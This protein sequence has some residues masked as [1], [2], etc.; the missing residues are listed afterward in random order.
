MST[1]SFNPFLLAD[2]HRQRDTTTSTAVGRSSPPM[3]STTATTACHATAPTRTTTT[4]I[5]SFPT[6]LTNLV[7]EE[8]CEEYCTL[9]QDIMMGDRAVKKTKPDTL[10]AVQAY[11]LDPCTIQNHSRN[12]DFVDD[13]EDSSTSST[14][15]FR[16]VAR[17][18]YRAFLDRHGF[19]DKAQAAYLERCL[20]YTADWCAKK[21][22]FAPAAMAWLKLRE[23]GYIPRE[24]TVSTFLFVF[25]LE[26]DNNNDKRSNA[27]QIAASHFLQD[28]AIFHDA[29]F[30]PNEK[31][32]YLRIKSL[33]AAGRAQEADDLLL[34]AIPMDCQR[35]RTFTPLLTHYCCIDDHDKN[36]SEDDKDNDVDAASHSLRLFRHMRNAPG[37]YLDADTYVMLLTSLAQREFFSCQDENDKN[38]NVGS[39]DM[40]QEAGFPVTGPALFD[41]LM[42][43]MST[44]LLE[45]NET[46]AIALY[47][48]LQSAF[49]T[50]E[51]PFDDV[52]NKNARTGMTSLPLAASH[53]SSMATIT[54]GRVTVDPTTC[55][56]PAT[57]AKL[58]LFSLTA[59]QRTMVQHTLLNMAAAQHEEFAAKMQQRNKKRSAPESS[60]GAYA[61]KQ[62]SKF[63]DWVSQH[64]FT[65]IIDG[66]NIAYFGH[67]VLYYNQLAL[68]V[69]HLERLGERP[70]VTM[71]SKYCQPSFYVASIGSEQVL[72]ERDLQVIADLKAKGQ[73][74][75]VPEWC[76][77]DYYWM[78]ASVVAPSTSVA[79]D[80]EEGGVLPGLR[81][82]LITNDQMR[83]HKLALLE[84]RLFRRWTS[85]HIV[86]YNF[87]SYEGDEWQANRQ[88]LLEHADSFSREVQGNAVPSNGDAK[89]LVWHIPVSEW[90]EDYPNDRFCI[91]VGPILSQQ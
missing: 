53:A 56:C 78:I 71:P 6:F 8:M 37:V 77:D 60:S 7:T 40:M 70:L 5:S 46:N 64:N 57:K 18:R 62:L 11:L 36:N 13:N 54:M 23:T 68:M 69:E 30:E 33:V 74:Y 63:V 43:E 9:M 50:N 83:D 38:R 21:K 87:S 28:V 67:A 20:G 31:T 15:G 24:N 91:C 4:S 14:D 41:S 89:T 90:S 59:D 88:I 58:Q 16:N 73:F 51:D 80:K 52:A 86:R 79:A 76:L 2:K 49:S 85:C 19:W 75:T 10:P 66:P 65:A 42:A 81:P 27:Q 17:E 45:F 35:L 84:P 55:L 25:G 44:D 34:H 47:K 61:L 22:M 82:L 39:R 1:S 48:S 29:C 72:S 12:N 32:V 3:L 26:H